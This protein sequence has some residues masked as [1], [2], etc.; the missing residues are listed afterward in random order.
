MPTQYGIRVFNFEP[1]LRCRSSTRQYYLR[2]LNIIACIETK[3]AYG[4][5][6][7]DPLTALYHNTDDRISPKPE[8]K[9]ADLCIVLCKPSRCFVSSS[10]CPIVVGIQVPLEKFISLKLFS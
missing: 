2:F 3:L 1:E 4:R 8:L 5:I 10:L 9:F 6:G 7:F